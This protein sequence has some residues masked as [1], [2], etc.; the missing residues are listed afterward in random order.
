MYDI[1]APISETTISYLFLGE[2][3]TCTERL[4]SEQRRTCHQSLEIRQNSELCTEIKGEQKR[5]KLTRSISPYNNIK[6]QI[7]HRLKN[8]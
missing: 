8:V 5:F 3:N 4:M 1:F 2:C 7:K 6:Q